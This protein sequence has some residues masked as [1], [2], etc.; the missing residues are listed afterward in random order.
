MLT[1]YLQNLL[2]KNSCKYH[3]GSDVLLLIRHFEID[4]WETCVGVAISLPEKIIDRQYLD[5]RCTNGI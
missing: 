3:P 5:T 1:R 2:Y 4:L